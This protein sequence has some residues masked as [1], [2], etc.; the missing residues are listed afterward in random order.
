MGS[1]IGKKIRGVYELKEPLGSGGMA[2]VYKAWHV[3]M[4]RYYA[5]KIVSPYILKSEPSFK[6]RLL[7]EAQICHDLDHQNIVKVFDFGLEDD[8]LFIIM[9]YFDGITLKKIL[10]SDGKQSLEDT[11][12]VLTEVAKAL[13]YAH[14][15]HKGS[16]FHRDIKPSNIMI[17]KQKHQVLLLDFGIVKASYNL[18]KALTDVGVQIGTP[19]Y[20]S[21]EQANGD[22]ITALSDIYSLG[23]VVYEMLT[24]TVP[25]TANTPPLVLLK[26]IKDPP[27]PLS[28]YRPDVPVEVQNAV[29]RALAKN[30]KDRYQSAGEFARNF[31]TEKKEVSSSVIRI[32]HDEVIPPIPAV[33]TQPEVQKKA[34]PKPVKPK[35]P[36]KKAERKVKTARQQPAMDKTRQFVLILLILIMLMC[37]LTILAAVFLANY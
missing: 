30:P 16:V 6:D 15:F 19:E 35:K 11:Q 18:N 32:T 2:T 34:E 27:E 9:P 12:F 22:Q 26:Q 28:K 33:N 21:P 23:I 10:A 37:F 14:T 8:M 4:Q 1:L 5:V 29:S 3:Y 20:M 24:G 25:F 36:V 31:L 17:N 13:D 7:N